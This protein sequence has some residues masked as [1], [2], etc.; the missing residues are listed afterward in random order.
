MDRDK[1]H[2]SFDFGS[3]AEQHLSSGTRDDF[4]LQVDRELAIVKRW[5]IKEDWTPNLIEKLQITVSSSYRISRALVPAWEGRQGHVEFPARRIN[6]SKA[7]IAHE[8]VHVFFPNGNRLLAEGLAIYLQQLIGGNPAFPNFGRPLH[9]AAREALADIVPGFAATDPEGLRAL[10]LTDLDQI[11]TP[12]PLTLRVGPHVYG[13]EPRGQWRLYLIAGSFVQFL[14]DDHGLENFRALY[15]RT[16]LMP[17]KLNSGTSGRWHDVYGRHLD[18][19]EAEW[20]SLIC[21]N[22]G[23]GNA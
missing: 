13:E 18:D 21:A 8:L 11:A 16:P 4:K 12:N 6:E 2:V 9:E 20:K 19:F 23:V 22:A 15:A 17:S 10:H 1:L 14:I 3:V 5:W 7:A